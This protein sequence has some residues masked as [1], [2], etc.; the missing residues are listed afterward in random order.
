MGLASLFFMHPPPVTNIAHNRLPPVLD[1]D[2]LHRHGLLATV[3]CFL[4]ASI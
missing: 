1:V 3:L 2:M 4:S